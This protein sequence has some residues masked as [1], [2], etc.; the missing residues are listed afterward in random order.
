M[1]MEMALAEGLFGSIP[2][3]I[4]L[5]MGLMSRLIQTVTP[6]LSATFI[7]PPQKHI[8]PRSPRVSSTAL[9]PPF[10]MAADTSLIRPLQMPNTTDR[11]IRPAHM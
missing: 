11:T 4:R 7:I 3:K 2:L 8:A 6:A 10:M 5:V 9:P 1:F